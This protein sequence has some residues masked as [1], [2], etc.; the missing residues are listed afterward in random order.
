MR[1]LPLA[2]GAV[3]LELA[4]RGVKANELPK[5]RGWKLSSRG[6][7]EERASLT[8]NKHHSSFA[9]PDS[10]GI[11]SFQLK[12]IRDAIRPTRSSVML[13][14]ANERSSQRFGSSRKLRDRA[15]AKLIHPAWQ[16]R[17][18]GEYRR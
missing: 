11:L 10:Q 6:L 5:C 18:E 8:K 14:M 12:G 7:G 9:K 2:E 3:A 4:R 16:L 13:G 17:G 1:A 15:L